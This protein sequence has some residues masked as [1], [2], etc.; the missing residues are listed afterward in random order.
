MQNW[1]ELIKAL[2][3]PFIIVCGFVIYGVCITGGITVPDLLSTLVA[4]AVLEYFGERAVLRL[5]DSR[6]NQKEKTQS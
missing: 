2:I 6:N 3:R 5:R 4:A 1:I